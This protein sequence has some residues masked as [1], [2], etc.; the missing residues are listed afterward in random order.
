MLFAYQTQ[1]PVRPSQVST[2]IDRPSPGQG[3]PN[4]YEQS[5]MLET[6]V[7]YFGP[8]CK[9]GKSVHLHLVSVHVW[10]SS[11]LLHTSHGATTSKRAAKTGCIFKNPAPAHHAVPT[12]LRSMPTHGLPAHCIP[13]VHRQS[14]FQVQHAEVSVCM[15]GE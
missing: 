3:N 2:S 13:W 8:S 4:Q 11:L 1:S 12:H 10:A 15:A 7:C 6:C 9:A 5:I 14:Q